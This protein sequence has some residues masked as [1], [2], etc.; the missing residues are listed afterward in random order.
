MLGLNQS[1]QSVSHIGAPLIGGLLIEHGWLAPC[2]LLAAVVS[3]A[4]LA[5]DR[6]VA[7]GGRA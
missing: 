6:A 4:A 7:Q 3:F 1:L 5:L 2:A